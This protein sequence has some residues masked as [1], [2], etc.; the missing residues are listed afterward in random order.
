ML[1]NLIMLLMIIGYSSGLVIS[2]V[3]LTFATNAVINLDW[4]LFV[5]WDVT[6]IF[7][8]GFIILIS[9]IET[10][11]R[12][13]L[14]EKM[15]LDLRAEIIKE[16]GLSSYEEFHKYE[17]DKYISWL[18]NDIKLIQENSF[19][20]FYDLI[21]YVFQVTF[22]IIALLSY[23][24]SL[25]LAV[26]L[27]TGIMLWSSNAKSKEV[28]KSMKIYSEEYEHFLGKLI[29]LIK[30]FNVFYSLN[31]Q[32]RLFKNTESIGRSLA[33]KKINLERDRAKVQV[34]STSVHITSSII[35]D[36]ITGTLAIMRVVTVGALSTT[37]T[38]S[39]NIFYALSEIVNL[40][41]DIKSTLPLF[42]KTRLI[43]INSLDN[44]MLHNAEDITSIE[45]KDIKFEFKNTT[46]L[47][48]FSYKFKKGKNYAFIGDSGSGKTTLLNII[49]SNLTP[50]EGKI[51]YNENS[52]LDYNI[53][54][55]R[56][57]IIYLE[58]KPIIF[59]TSILENIT[60]GEEF[61]NNDINRVL[62]DTGLDV[63]LRSEK[64]GLNKLCG[65]DGNFLS[66]GQKQRISIAR[67]L[68][69]K[70]SFLL[71]DESTSNLDKHSAISIE[72]K[73]LNNNK[74]TLLMVSHN[75]FESSAE[76]IDE[77][78]YI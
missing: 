74:L 44:H 60:M 46:I 2:S 32:A 23:H 19:D 69:R 51:I 36:L 34:I 47:K 17:S 75:L 42:D 55:K 38:L 49:A 21:T 61:S 71:F 28:S 68:I 31:L 27:L 5:L 25:L 70:P 76:L 62:L 41:T 48:K 72:K 78:I 30:G 6:I 45:L 57:E 22:S 43:K 26:L 24:Y 3:L 56:K 12:A 8:W 63:Y 77:K 20:K 33:N 73:L 53:Y 1:E 59:N 65:E 7:L 10:I 35:I 58:Q 52:S 50:S 64:D 66:G 18:T 11:Y 14:I 39:S 40:V 16:V 37:G 29:E 4:R 13:K 54:F 67:A 15:G 9:Y